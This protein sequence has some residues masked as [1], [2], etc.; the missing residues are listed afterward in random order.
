MFNVC[1][2]ILESI[3]SPCRN[4]KVGLLICT[5]KWQHQVPILSSVNVCVFL[6]HMVCAVSVW[7]KH[8]CLKYSLT[9]PCHLAKQCGLFRTNLLW[10]TTERCMCVSE[11]FLWIGKRTICARG[12]YTSLSKV[13]IPPP[14]KIH[15]SGILGLWCFL[16]KE[17]ENKCTSV[18]QKYLFFSTV[19]ATVW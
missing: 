14:S 1:H 10:L 2:E 7:Q 5:V 16:Q 6:K 12:I 17:E 8:L 11:P 13:S 3:E 15:L 18:K 4:W 9:V 19:I